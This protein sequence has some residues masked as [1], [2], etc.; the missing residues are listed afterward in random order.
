M[1]DLGPGYWWRDET[2]SKLTAAVNAYLDGRPLSVQE[3]SNLRA[4]FRHWIGASI[5]DR[6]PCASDEDRENLKAL[7]KAVDLMTCRDDVSSWLRHAMSL[8][9][10]PL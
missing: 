3:I 2:S 6:N 5:W 1:R 10:D 4:Y 7:R 9:M 8:G